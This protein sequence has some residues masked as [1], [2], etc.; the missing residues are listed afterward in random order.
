MQTLGLFSLDHVVLFSMKDADRPHYPRVLDLK[1]C[2]CGNE[3]C[4]FLCRCSYLFRAERERDWERA[5]KGIRNRTRRENLAEYRRQ[6]NG[7]ND[8]SQ[9]VTEDV[10]HNWHRRTGHQPEIESSCG[11][12]ISR[13]QHQTPDRVIAA[14]AKG[15][16]DQ[17]APR[18]PDYNGLSNVEGSREPS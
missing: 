18:V 8:R 12:I 9:G 10:T 15:H 5:F 16:R 2:G 4:T 11:K 17:S 1:L 3:E 6:H 14:Q 13:G 7:R